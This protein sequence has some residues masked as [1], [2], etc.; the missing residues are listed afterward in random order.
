MT[1]KNSSEFTGAA[2]STGTSLVG[3]VAKKVIPLTLRVT[4]SGVAL[5]FLRA[6][7]KLSLLNP[8][9]A[10]GAFTVKPI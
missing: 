4:K 7:G 8:N 5:V 6:S 2:L 3:A 9:I 10:R 1:S